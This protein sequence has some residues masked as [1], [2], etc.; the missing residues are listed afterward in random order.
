MLPSPTRLVAI[1]YYF[2]IWTWFSLIG[3]VA[4]E[5]TLAFIVKRGFFLHNLFSIHGGMEDKFIWILW[6]SIVHLH[7]HLWKIWDIE[8]LSQHT[9]FIYLIQLP[10]RPSFEIWVFDMRILSC[11]QQCFIYKCMELED[12]R[13]SLVYYDRYVWRHRRQY[14]VALRCMLH[15]STVAFCHLTTTCGL[16]C[17]LYHPDRIYLLCGPDWQLPTPASVGP[18]IKPALVVLWHR[19][20]MFSRVI[21][22]RQIHS[23]SG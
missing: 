5:K 20:E 17:R 22:K 14:V 6:I 15:R 9:Y 8:L 16:V 7:F 12:Y 10:K 1:E 11:L 21:Y 18:C 2:V 4:W 19:T 3:W 13:S 23:V